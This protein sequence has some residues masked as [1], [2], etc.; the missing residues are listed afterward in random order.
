MKES[1]KSFTDHTVRNGS[2]ISNGSL[3][4]FLGVLLLSVLIFPSHLW[5]Q[6]AP[7]AKA[8]KSPPPKAEA[9]RDGPV[10]DANIQGQLKKAQE[11]F[12]NKGY[13]SALKIYQDCYDY[14]KEVL[15]LVRF[16]KGQYEKA[17][18]G[19]AALSQSDKEEVYIKLR[20]AGQLIAK[21]ESIRDATLYP[22]GYLYAKKGATEKAKVYLK[23]AVET[24][25][26]SLKPDS[27]W[28]KA[29]TLLLSL[30][31]LEGEF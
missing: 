14:T 28:M 1:I 30:Y 31:Q 7:A 25:P 10:T 23:E 8:K 21:Y 3:T 18:S 5:S 13:D 12:K 19:Q 2:M 22:L 9:Q 29:K 26:F 17:S 11:L 24:F 27:S 20:R 15:P 4:L 6:P 16:M